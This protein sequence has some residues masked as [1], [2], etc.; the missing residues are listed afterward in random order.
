MAPTLG[1][2]DCGADGS[3]M[4]MR[5]MTPAHSRWDLTGFAANNSDVTCQ[6]VLILLMLSG[7]ERVFGVFLLPGLQDRNGVSHQEANKIFILQA[8]SVDNSQV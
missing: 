6:R 4:L 8:C 7:Q 5:S 3:G 1:D 2:A